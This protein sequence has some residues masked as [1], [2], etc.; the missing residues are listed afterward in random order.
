MTTVLPIHPLEDERLCL[1]LWQEEAFRVWS[2]RGNRGIVEAVTG[3][4]KTRLGLAAISAALREG[5]QALLLVPTIEL[6]H[7]WFNEIRTLLPWAVVGRL[8][9]QYRDDF[10]HHQ[11]IVSTVQSALARMQASA[12]YGLSGNNSRLLIADE[13]HRLAA[14]RYSTALDRSFAWRLGLSATYERPDDKH[15]EHLDPYFGG[16]VYRLW[17]DRAQQDNLIAPFDIALVGVELAPEERAKYSEL[18][19]TISRSHRSLLGYLPDASLVGSQFLAIVA[20]WAAEEAMTARTALARKYMRAVSARQQLLAQTDAKL[21]Q[22]ELIEPALRRARST[23][24]FSLTQFGAQEAADRVASCGISATAV[25][26]EISGVERKQRMA[27]FRSGAVPVLAAPRVLDEGVDVPEAELGIVL[28]TSRSKRQL[29]QR[30]GRVIRRKADG[31][32]G[33][34]V[35]FYAANTIE[36]PEHRGDEQYL[37]A[38]LPHARDL[39]WF[40]LP[41]DHLEL[42][43][44]LENLPPQTPAPDPLVGS[45]PKRQVQV[46][47]PEPIRFGKA[48]GE[49][50]DGDTDPG[51]TV[52]VQRPAPKPPAVT[53]VEP[54]TPTDEEPEAW[55]GEVPELLRG[56]A[57]LGRDSTHFY[58]KQIGGFSLLTAE[59]ETE[60]GIAI[61]QGV[62]A[63]ER[64]ALGR[65]QLRRERRELEAI[66]R[67][68]AQA[69]RR[70]VCANLRLVVSTARRYRW[71][72]GTLDFLDLVQEGN[73]GLQR[74]IQKWDYARGLKF[75]TYA[76]WW[77]QQSI[78]RAMADSARTIRVP[79]HKAEEMKKA[80]T[81]RADA[82]RTLDDDAAHMRAAEQM[83]L[84]TS[85][86][87]ELFALDRPPA[88]LDKP[89][90]LVEPGHIQIITLG[91]KIIDE[92][93]Q[94]LE[95][96]LSRERF[97]VLISESLA[98]LDYRTETIMRLRF[99]LPLPESPGQHSEPLTLDAIGEQVGVTRERVRQIERQA[100]KDL[101]R[102]LRSSD[103]W[104]W[105]PE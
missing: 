93:E 85:A 77:I 87:T 7:Q 30:L 44:F 54:A 11:V 55:N 47:Q 18:S 57:P 74:A 19:D 50:G 81:L 2:D 45:T 17:Y 64:L 89:E 79:V 97:A 27:E 105:L 90:W 9:D 83:G 68:G 80:A 59:E 72:S 8:G 92:Y 12:I 62:L 37:N 21:S 20:G 86:L 5:R 70:F 24:L 4:G 53:S 39:G 26:S 49:S 71:G 95:A 98:Q 82:R 94:P 33:K 100:K 23:L 46:P 104:G 96:G 41:E 32:A 66:V 56:K 6:L 58:L 13:V 75:S 1:Y 76:T 35:F 29:V 60:L 48:R 102:I 22:L 42:L 16:V 25:Y 3:A 84:S 69:H 73:L 91:A 40:S 28:A 78:T 10:L 52:E 99:G 31:R 38:V 43:R 51:E 15:L 36:D 63:Q 14:D 61:E 103:V 88:S 34:F 67:K 101:A 65:Y